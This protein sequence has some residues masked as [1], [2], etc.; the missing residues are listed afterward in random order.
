MKAARDRYEPWDTYVADV[1]DRAM[2]L[3]VPIAEEAGRLLPASG[4]EFMMCSPF[5]TDRHPSLYLCPKKGVW[6]DRATGETGDAIDFYRKRHRCGFREAVDGLARKAGMLTWEERRPKSG[7]DSFATEEGLFAMW[8]GTEEGHDVKRCLTDLVL[9]CH[10]ELPDR[11]REHLVRDRGLFPETIDAEKIGWVPAALW[12]MARELEDIDEFGV[13]K[14]RYGEDLLWATGMFV[15]H[16]KP[17]LRGYSQPS[18]VHRILFPY[19]RQGQVVYAIGRQYH[20]GVTVPI[21]AES[22]YDRGGTKHKFKKLLTHNSDRTTISPVIEND[23]LWGEDCLRDIAGKTLLIGEGIADVLSLKQIG[24]PVL[25]PITVRF[26]AE[27]LQRMAGSLRRCN[28]VVLLNDNDEKRTVADDPTDLDHGQDAVRRPGWEGAVAT[29]EALTKLGIRVRIGTV[30]KPEGASKS[31]VNSELAKGIADWQAKVDDPSRTDEEREMI[32]KERL[33]CLRR[34]VKEW[35]DHAKPLVECL[36][37][38]LPPD[39]EVRD[40][41]AVIERAGRSLVAASDLELDAIAK[42]VSDRFPFERKN[43]RKLLSKAAKEARAEEETRPAETAEQQKSRKVGVLYD[44]L[45]YYEKRS[46]GSEPARISTFSL[47]L[48]KVIL[49]ED[50]HGPELAHVDVI[51][52]DQT[53][54]FHGWTVPPR[55]WSSKKDFIRSFPSMRMQWSGSDDDVQAVYELLATEMDRVVH[56]RGTHVLGWQDAGDAPRVVVRAGTLSPQGWMEVPDIEWIPRY[57]GHVS[58]AQNYGAIG[59]KMLT[60]Q[61]PIH[62]ESEALLREVLSSS[63]ELYKPTFSVPVILWFAAA[64]A[65]PI[66][67]KH[68]SGFPLL[69]VYGSSGSGKTT[70]TRFWWRLFCGLKNHEPLSI[71]TTTFTFL[72]DMSS[73]NCFPIFYDEFRPREFSVPDLKNLQAALRGAYGGETASRGRADQGVNHYNMA[74]PLLIAGETRLDADQAIVERCVYAAADRSWLDSPTSERVRD[75]F[76]SLRRKPIENCAS[77]IHRWMTQQ[78]FDTILASASE[79][80]DTYFAQSGLSIASD[81]VRQNLI[82]MVVGAQILARLADAVNATLPAVDLPAILTHLFRETI[83]FDGTGTDKRSGYTRDQFDAFVEDCS[84]MAASGVLHEGVEFSWIHGKLFLWLQGIDA[85][86]ATWLQRQNRPDS[87]VGPRAL[88][89]IAE[90]KKSR[91]DYVL[92]T[93]ARS[94]TNAPKGFQ[95]GSNGFLP[96]T[97]RNRPVPAQVRGILLD[98]ERAPSCVLS[99]PQSTNRVQGREA[100]PEEILA[101]GTF[102]RGF[103]N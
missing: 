5:R 32:R 54:V 99:F 4:G 61:T 21:N 44:Q 90:E 6:L 41:T 12:E 81:R 27:D 91:G 1:R 88:R 62:A 29:A 25:S 57:G 33:Q 7:P 13:C 67:Q 102:S 65:K 26:K 59:K 73:S 38:A 52:K 78:K 45:S 37:D 100:A 3:L 96:H 69:N 101:Q 14:P 58:N 64:L 82:A 48:R 93:D 103:E 15:P 97:N 34:K 95:E 92:D 86:R 50:G 17:E 2:D 47:A 35:V 11:V 36:L 49:S 66:F 42:T 30:T 55:A 10:R 76:S 40:V 51:G 46:P 19:W 56:V 22:G 24:F 23:T 77:F 70:F 80:A 85:A 18:L 63:F 98:P 39:V 20:E 53:I 79:A 89:K 68:F 28:E 72:H 94:H 9:L 60:A 71:R 84:I 31:D 83:D 74:A 8:R 87:S 75:R 16:H 43:V